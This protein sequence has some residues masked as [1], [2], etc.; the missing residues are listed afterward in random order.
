MGGTVVLIDPLVP[1]DGAAEAERFWEALDRD[2]ARTGERPLAVLVSNEFHGRSAD[3]VRERYGPSPGC[4]VWVP[5]AARDRVAGRAT[6]T[7]EAGAKLPGGAVPHFIEGLVEPEVAFFL[8]HWRALVVADAL[9]GDGAGRVR[10]PPLSWATP[11]V[12]GER[13]YRE[14]FR[15]SVR[16][17]LDTAPEVLLTSH[18][19][20]VLS[21]ARG[22]IAAAVAADPL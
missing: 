16:S 17:L 19:E 6:D 10:L 12:D 14:R 18:G 20:P 4:S 1:A 8:P 13:R 9:L 15:A 22:A 2:V 11:G 3:A 21:G 7:F 5:A